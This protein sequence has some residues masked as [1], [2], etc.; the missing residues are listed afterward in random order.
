MFRSWLCQYATVIQQSCFSLCT[1]KGTNNLSATQPRKEF[2]YFSQKKKKKK[3]RKCFKQVVC[4]KKQWWERESNNPIELYHFRK[5]VILIPAQANPKTP[6]VNKNRQKNNTKLSLNCIK[7]GIE[8]G[9]RD[10]LGFW[11]NYEHCT[12]HNIMKRSEKNEECVI[13]TLCRWS[14]LS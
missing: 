14:F 8:K 4:I 3:I 11:L 1:H 10:R 5:L 7:I 13:I 9:E 2:I 6:Q 12:R